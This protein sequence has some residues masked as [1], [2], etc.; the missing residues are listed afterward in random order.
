[1]ATLKLPF[2]FYNSLGVIIENVSSIFCAM[3]MEQKMYREPFFNQISLVLDTIF[4]NPGSYRDER[5]KIII[6]N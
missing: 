6:E 1:M 5:T 4:F 2:I 3:I